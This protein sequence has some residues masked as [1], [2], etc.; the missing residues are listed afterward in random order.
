MN[1]EI[2][3]NELQEILVTIQEAHGYDFHGYSRASFLRRVNRFMQL[4][5]LNDF[6]ALKEKLVKDEGFFNLFLEQIT[7]NVTEMF[8]D[9]GFYK[10][11]REKVV[12]QLR[13]FPY[14]RIWDAGCSTGEEPYSLAIMLKEEG[15]LQKSK[16]YC[17]DINQKVLN[18][19]REGVFPLANM[20]DYTSNYIQAGGTGNFSDY[21][22]AKYNRVLF[23]AEL[24]KNMVFSVHNLASD[25]SFNEFNLIVCRNVLIYFNK[26]LQEKVL[27]LFLE[28][29]S[30]FGYLAL[31]SKE[32]LSLSPLRDHFEQV[33]K[34]EK[35]YR[36]IK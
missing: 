22:M 23:D 12:P 31:G 11:L 34:K 10:S 15:T 30:M 8:R 26:E 2:G 1:S 29:L 6:S 9:P 35:I 19:A 17:T 7:V 4:N 36:R 14:I 3:I 28:S 16:M 33:D 25:S 13:T 32:T 21:Y 27:S 5:S 18:Q 24:R 20:K